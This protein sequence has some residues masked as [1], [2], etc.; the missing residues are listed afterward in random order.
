M[1]RTASESKRPVNQRGVVAG[2]GKTKV[3]GPGQREN[4]VSR[5]RELGGK[6]ITIGSDAHR[7]GDVG[8]GLEEG[9]RLAQRC[10]FSYVTVFEKRQP[11][12][13]PID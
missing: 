11:V 3:T 12:L 2:A 1:T 7:W 9:Y 8:S 4:I 10:G 13:L 5:F 6:Y